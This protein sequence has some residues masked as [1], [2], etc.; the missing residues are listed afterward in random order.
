MKQL[1]ATAR[2]L[3]DIHLPGVTVPMIEC[4]LVM[5]EPDFRVDAAGVLV[6][7]CVV[8]NMRFTAT[9]EILR[10]TADRF[11]EWADEAEALAKQT[12]TNAEKK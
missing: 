12:N 11:R 10:E 9:L 2:N 4:I 5:T 1:M 6:R 3:I 7:E 8:Q